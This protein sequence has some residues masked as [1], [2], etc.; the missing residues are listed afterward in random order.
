M[1]NGK[2]IK[3]YSFILFIL[4]AAVFTAG[5]GLELFGQQPTHIPDPKAEPVKFFDSWTNVVLYVILPVLIITFYV[6][7]RWRNHKAGKKQQEEAARK[8]KESRE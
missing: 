6:I 4:L 2:R 8:R 5:S 7:W 3:S 1:I